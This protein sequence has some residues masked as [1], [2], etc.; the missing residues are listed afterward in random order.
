MAILNRYHRRPLCWSAARAVHHRVG[1]R[2]CMAEVR[3]VGVLWT[4][5]LY[6]RHQVRYPILGTSPDCIGN[7]MGFAWRLVRDGTLVKRRRE[8]Q[9]VLAQSAK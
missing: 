5:C 8:S 4:V 7:R 6:R 2:S 1:S 9:R 3:T